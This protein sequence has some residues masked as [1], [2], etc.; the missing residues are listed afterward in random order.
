MYF[1]GI[2]R[3]ARTQRTISEDER[4]VSALL[5]KKAKAQGDAEQ[6]PHS[7]LFDPDTEETEDMLLDLPAPEKWRSEVIDMYVLRE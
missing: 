3:R 6:S 5:A 2:A 1:G 7:H 4:V